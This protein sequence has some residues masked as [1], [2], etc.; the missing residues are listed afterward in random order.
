MIRSRIKKHNKNKTLLHISHEIRLK[1]TTN[2]NRLLPA[3]YN[4]Y[5]Q[6]QTNNNKLTNI[7][8]EI[9]T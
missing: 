8:H 6:K 7:S 1:S 5:K 3:F 2:K 4:T 9:I